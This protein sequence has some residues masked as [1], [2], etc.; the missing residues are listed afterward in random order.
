MIIHQKI[1]HFDL[2]SFLTYPH[3]PYF[4]TLVLICT[5][6]KKVGRFFKYN[7]LKLSTSTI[8]KPVLTSS[9]D[10]TSYASYST[11]PSISSQINNKDITTNQNK[12]NISNTHDIHSWVTPRKQNYS[13]QATST[14]THLT[15][16]NAT[17][18]LT[19]VKLHTTIKLPL[20]GKKY[21]VFLINQ[22][23]SQASKCM[24]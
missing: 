19:S 14:T 24:K 5:M 8:K 10:H 1:S 17:M 20:T 2:L 23:Q 11:R 18:Y 12:N 3:L 13:G 16:L 22:K 15:P 4:C 21:L 6:G 7:W 9:A